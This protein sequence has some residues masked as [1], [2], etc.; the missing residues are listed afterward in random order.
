MPLVSRLSQ[1]LQT[2]VVVFLILPVFILLFSG[3]LAG[4]FYA[5]SVMLEQWNESAALKLERAAHYIEMRVSRPVDLLE[6]IF[7][8]RD[9]QDMNVFKNRVTGYL[10]QL[11]GVVDASFVYNGRN[12]SLS[13][14]QMGMRNHDKRMMHF[15]RGRIIKV[16]SPGYNTEKGQETVRILLSLLDESENPAG[17]IEIAMSFDYLLKDII[18]LGWWQSDM[19]CLV[20]SSGTYLS[21][22][23]RV[24]EGR[25]KLGGTGDPLELAVLEAMQEKRSGTVNGEGA[26]ENMVAG[27]YN[28]DHTPWTIILFAE[29]TK[30]LGPIIRYRNG[31]IFGSIVLVLAI[32]FLIRFQVGKILTKIRRISESAGKVGQGI[33]EELDENNPPDEI[34]HLIKSYNSMIKGLRERDLIRDSFGRYIDPEFARTLLIEPKTGS[35]VGVRKEVVI[36]MA[37]IRG[38]TPIIEN[39]SPEETIRMMNRYFSGMIEVIQRHNGIIVDFIGDGIL[40]FFQPV[41]ESMEEV[42][43][44]GVDCAL[45]MQQEMRAFNREMQ[46]RKLP[47]MHMGIGI[48]AGQVIVGNI[49]SESRKKYGIVG[50]A[51]NAVHRIQAAAQG[52]QVVVSDRVAHHLNGG[53]PI[54]ESFYGELKGFDEKVRLHLLK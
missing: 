45:S 10:E 43:R 8:T 9:F 49:G 51:V 47:Q 13:R 53:I 31:F 19:A 32:L 30:I 50:S 1:S 12:R 20:D 25:K 41:H 5:R 48:N 3:G 38:F 54:R 16:S 26:S 7:K 39:L 4:L 28:L 46:E 27:F 15:T 37:D 24:M 2:R 14:E 44:K 17:R 22:L 33:Y 23:N 52:G 29:R 36:V 11:E 42:A 18:E 6:V 40:V 34:G 21:H 35:L